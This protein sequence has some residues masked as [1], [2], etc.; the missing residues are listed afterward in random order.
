MCGPPSALKSLAA[1]TGL[2]G[3]ECR[4]RRVGAPGVNGRKK[5]E[6]ERDGVAEEARGTNQGEHR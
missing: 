3:S 2:E 5:M 1:L 4:L 6:G